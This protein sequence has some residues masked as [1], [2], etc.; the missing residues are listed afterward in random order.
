MRIQ[1]GTRRRG[2]LML[3]EKRLKRWGAS[4][5]SPCLLSVAA[6][7]SLSVIKG[8]LEADKWRLRQSRTTPR[9]WASTFVSAS[10]PP[11]LLPRFPFL[12]KNIARWECDWTIC[13]ERLLSRQRICQED[14]FFAVC[15]SNC[16]HHCQLWATWCQVIFSIF[17]F[18]FFCMGFNLPA[19]L[20]CKAVS[21]LFVIFEQNTQMF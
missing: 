21:K 18:C 17:G 5:A 13:M 12:E 1:Q 8:T 11:V 4:R 15:A 7:T 6:M 10:P 20:F 3:A 2:R 14:Y 19:F 16:C 9:L